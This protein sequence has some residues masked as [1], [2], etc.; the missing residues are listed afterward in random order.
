MSH[1]TASHKKKTDD[2]IGGT[3]LIARGESGADAIKKRKDLRKKLSEAPQQ[4]RARVS[5]YLNNGET[6]RYHSTK[7]RRNYREDDANP[8]SMDKL[9]EHQKRA[10]MKRKGFGDRAV[11]ADINRLETQRLEAA[12]A[13]VDAEL[14]LHTE[15]SGFLEVENEMEKTYKLTQNQLKEHL[16]EQTAKKIFDLRLDQYSPY[17][18]NYDP[19]GRCGL[20]FG[21]NGG[22]IAVMDMHTLSHQLCKSYASSPTP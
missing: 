12:M 2:N 9:N 1:L 22:H 10:L 8:R 18:L 19:S 15:D 13:A 3:S 14:V 17:G 11:K 16:D 4:D 5:E 7:R 20:L 6:S 21:K